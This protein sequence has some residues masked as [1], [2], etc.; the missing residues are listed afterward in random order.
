MWQSRAVVGG[1]GWEKQTEEAV[2]RQSHG[3]QLLESHSIETESPNR[4]E[5][6]KSYKE[7]TVLGN[8]W[9][10]VGRQSERNLLPC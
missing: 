1:G 7:A 5:A 9:V 4:R 8:K 2:R 3:P 6:C 10:L